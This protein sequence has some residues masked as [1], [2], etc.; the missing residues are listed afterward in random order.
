MYLCCVQ[1]GGDAVPYGNSRHHYHHVLVKQHSPRS[2]NLA[3]HFHFVWTRSS[4]PAFG[5]DITFC[6]SQPF[7]SFMD[8]RAETSPFLPLSVCLLSRSAGAQDPGLCNSDP[9][10]MHNISA[11]VD[12]KL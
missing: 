10:A 7:A 2:L 5:D 3:S 4:L 1:V 6:K 11:G 8:P 12:E 9:T